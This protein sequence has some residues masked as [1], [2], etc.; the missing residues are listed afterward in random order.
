M[1]VIIMA[2]G[3]GERLRPLTDTIP[4]PMIDVNGKP[5]LEHI[6]D[7]FKKFDIKDFIFSLCYLPQVITSYFGDGSK[8]GI[9]VDYLIEDPNKP[10]G[11][12]GGIAIAKKYIKDTFIVTSGDILRKIDVNEIIKF[13][14]R[15]DSF[16]TLNTYKR[17]GSDPKS[18]LVFN[19]ENRI[20]DFIERPKLITNHHS[21]VTN[22]VWSNGS[23][24]VFEPEI[25]DYI[26]KNKSSDFGK[27]IF[28]KLLVDNKKIYAFPTEDYFVDIGNLAK[29]EIARTTFK[30]IV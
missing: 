2:G 13:H 19:K 8:F 10:M 22:Y 7:L 16:A 27:D 5:V 14:K 17:F 23:F 21:L 26:P 24:Y 28:P 3:R 25:F 9:H 11:T 6:V 15:K 4:K 20:I 29:L 12:A 1:K 30:P 18:M